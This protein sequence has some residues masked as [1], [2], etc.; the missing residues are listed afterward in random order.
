MTSSAIRVL[1]TGT[2][3]PGTAPEPLLVKHQPALVRTPL[4]LSPATFTPLRRKAHHILFYSPYA[5]DVVARS[6]LLPLDM[7]HQFWAVGEKTAEKVKECFQKDAHFPATQDFE[8]LSPLL[9]KSASPLD[10]VAFGL[11]HT[12]RDLSPVAAAW[13]VA[14][15]EVPVYQSLPT[16]PKELREVFHAFQPRWINFTSSRGV[17]ALIAAL[18][19]DALQ[20]PWREKNLFFAAIGPS[21][22]QTLLEN[23]LSPALIPETPDRSALLEGIK[24]LEKA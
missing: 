21:T 1:D 22:E 2:R 7:D 17:E 20:R 12:S 19:V 15:R 5:V 6:G 23:G 14:F 8:H 4:D 13:D 24:N 18:G 9:E 3:H 11:L 10:I 16:S